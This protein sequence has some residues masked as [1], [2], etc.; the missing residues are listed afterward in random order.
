MAG[1]SNSLI[2]QTVKEIKN[3]QV[4]SEDVNDFLNLKH[5]D[6]MYRKVDTKSGM[7]L[8][9]WAIIVFLFS[10]LLRVSH[11]VVSP[12]TLLR[13]DIQFYKWGVLVTINSSKTKDILW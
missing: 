8:L 11:V 13:E 12:H 9:I 1:W 2:S 5:L 6:Q 3:S 4:A 7:G 10:T